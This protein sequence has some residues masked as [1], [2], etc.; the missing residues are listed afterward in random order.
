MKSQIVPI[1]FIFA[2]VLVIFY[3]YKMIQANQIKRD[4]MTD[5]AMTSIAIEKANA[6]GLTFGQA[7]DIMAKNTTEN[8]Y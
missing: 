3:I 7:M 2:G 1:I 6:E 4:I 5:P 8:L